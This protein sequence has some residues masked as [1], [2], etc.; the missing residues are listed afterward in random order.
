MASRF[1][2]LELL[3]GLLDT[4]GHN[5]DGKC[6]D[7]ISKSKRLAEGVCFLARSLGFRASMNECTKRIKKTGFS[8]Q[9]FRLTISGHLSQIPC[10]IERKKANVRKMKK[11]VLRKGF[12]IAYE[13]EDNYFGFCLDGNHR[14]LDG[15]FMVHHNS[16]KTHCI[17]QYCRLLPKARIIV[18]TYSISVLETIYRNV[19]KVV[20]GRCGLVSGSKLINPDARVVCISSGK[21]P[22]YFGEREQNADVILLD[23]VHEHGSLKRLEVLR[24]V[25]S[26]KLFGFSANDTRPD[27]AEFCLKGIFGPV[28]AKMN[29]NEAV[30][31]NMVTPIVVVWCPTPCRSDPGERIQNSVYAE[32][33]RIWRNHGRNREI[34]RIAGMFEDTDQVLI[35]VKTVEHLLQLKQLLPDFAAA[36]SPKPYEEMKKFYRH[37]GIDKVPVLSKDGLS[38]LTRAFEK[39]SVKKCISTGVWSRG[40]DFRELQVLIRA[41]GA[42]SVI[43]D[44]Q[45]PGRTSRIADGKTISFVFDFLDEFSDKTAGKAQERRK[46]YAKNG[47]KQISL[48]D[49]ERLAS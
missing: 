16:G 20:E 32:K 29:Y 39:G 25:R 37:A 12:E 31:N 2:R 30:D 33:M 41:D 18:S 28:I 44:T 13:G 26:A 27:K 49:F 43:F 19:S 8:G 34:A 9:Y 14:Y 10:R 21:L 42:N 38:H 4:D 22:M 17:A 48:K 36:Y 47:W 6:Y 45:I 35:N 5:E 3:A 7:Y 11:D 1:D 46:R 15:Q 40:V 23:E 24:N